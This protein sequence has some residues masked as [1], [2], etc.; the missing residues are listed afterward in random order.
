MSGPRPARMLATAAG[1]ARPA[2]A[3]LSATAQRCGELLCAAHEYCSR[4]LL[5]CRPCAEICTPESRNFQRSACDLQCQGEWRVSVALGVWRASTAGGCE[6][7]S[8]ALEPLTEVVP[9]LNSVPFL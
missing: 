3:G 5:R 6:N 7:T 8:R 1:V 9:S 4:H 2:L